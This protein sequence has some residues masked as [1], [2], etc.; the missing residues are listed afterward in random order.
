M[1]NKTKDYIE[2]PECGWWTREW[3]LI[4]EFALE[5]ERNILSLLQSTINNKK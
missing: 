5:L 3:V 1:P 2:C 4:Y